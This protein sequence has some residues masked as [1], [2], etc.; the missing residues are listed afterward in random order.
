[1]II[2]ITKILGSQGLFDAISEKK[3]EVSQLDE[4]KAVIGKQAAKPWE[5]LVDHKNE[6]LATKEAQDLVSKLLVYNPDQRL[7]A[8]AALSHNFFDSVRSD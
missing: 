4:L 3:Y 1:M 2:K 5:K 8:K 6:S 7:T